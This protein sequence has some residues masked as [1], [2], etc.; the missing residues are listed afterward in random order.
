MQIR[1]KADTEQV[2]R[3]LNDSEALEG[4]FAEHA[5]V[6][7]PERRYDFWGRYT[8][9]NPDREAGRHELQSHRPGEQ[10][11]F[12][13]NLSGAG[14]AVELALVPDGATTLVLVQ[15]SGLGDVPHDGTQA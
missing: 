13:W 11:G 1:L 2:F 15:H 6:E 3:A 10:L 4:W 5:Q 12:G 9:E 7:I 8:P 14:T